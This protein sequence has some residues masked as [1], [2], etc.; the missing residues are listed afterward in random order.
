MHEQHY[1]QLVQKCILIAEPFQ[2]NINFNA[3]SASQTYDIAKQE[4][5]LVN[6]HNQCG[7][8]PGYTQFIARHRIDLRLQR[9]E[10]FWQGHLL[11]DA[12]VLK[13][14]VRMSRY[15]SFCRGLNSTRTICSLLGGSWPIT[16]R[17]IRRSRWGFSFLCSWDTCRPWRWP[18]HRVVMI[19]ER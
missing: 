14:R 10:I 2:P 5:R 11:P 18:N 1:M 19:L 7:F 16:S 4:K 9:A 17:F 8:V 13:L 6:T 12:K 15:C 3:L